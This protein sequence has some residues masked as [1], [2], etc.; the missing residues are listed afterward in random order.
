MLIYHMFEGRPTGP[1][2]RARS[3]PT[4]TG[5]I[6]VIVD[7]ALEKALRTLKLSGM[8]QTLEA[9]LAQARAGELGHID[10]LQVL[11]HDEIARRESQRSPDASA[12]LTSSNSSHWRSSTTRPAP[13]YLPLRSATWPRCAGFPPENQWSSRARSVLGNPMWHKGLDT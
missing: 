3:R 11:C 4:R 13:S 10:F 1:P 8:L 9:R 7:A 12:E 5:G 2:C 6:R